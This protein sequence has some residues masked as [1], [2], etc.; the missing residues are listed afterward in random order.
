MF[1]KENKIDCPKTY[2][3]LQETKVA[4][5]TKELT[6]PVITKPRWGMGSIGIFLAEDETELD[7]FTKKI[8]RQIFNSYLK[9]ESKQDIEECILHQEKI[10]GIEYGLDVFND[11]N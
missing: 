3:S 10:S 9:Y 6:Y 7:L 8:R 1:L 2:K 11:F 4:L 5:N